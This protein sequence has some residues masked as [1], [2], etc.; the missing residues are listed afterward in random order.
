MSSSAKSRSQ[1]GQLGVMIIA[2]RN[3]A[4]TEEAERRL[5]LAIFIIGLVLWCQ[6]APTTHYVETTMIRA[7][8]VTLLAP[9][10]VVNAQALKPAKPP[11]DE[12]DQTTKSL[13]S[14]LTKQLKDR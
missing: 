14:V 6:L 3:V 11:A 10:A 1:G 2:G 4:V 7:A 12:L 9:S 13:V 5:F 8:V